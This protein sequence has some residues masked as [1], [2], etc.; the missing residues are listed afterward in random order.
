[1]KPKQ[2][3]LGQLLV[4]IDDSL[5]ICDAKSC[6]HSA[7]RAF[8]KQCGTSEQAII[9]HPLSQ[10]ISQSEL[11]NNIDPLKQVFK[12]NASWSGRLLVG[13]SGHRV[14]KSVEIS[15]IFTNKHQPKL[16]LLKIISDDQYTTTTK[17][18]NK[19]NIDELT[20]LPNQVLLK[21][22]IQQSMIN[23]KRAGKSVAVLL[24]SID[25][26][27]DI[28]AG[29]GQRFSDE[30]ICQVTG[31]L[32]NCIRKSDT[33]ARLMED[34]FAFVLQVTASDDSSIVSR[35]LLHSTEAA[36]AIDQQTVHIRASVGIS[37]YPSDS[38]TP[39]GLIELAFSAL[40][41]ARQEGG[42]CYD[43]FS[44]EMNRR[45]KARIEMEA[46]LRHGI[47]KNEFQ[48]FYQPK[49]RADDGRIVGMEGLIRWF[50][51]GTA[52]VSPGEFIP[53]AEETG[54]IEPIGMWVLEEACRQNKQWQ[55]Q[56]LG[57][58]K[59]SINVSG[60]QLNNPDFV[61]H[62]QDVINRVHINPEFLEL[63]I[64]ESMLAHNI[65]QTINKLQKI[66][67]LGCYLSIDDFGTGY[68]SLSYLTR[69]PITALKIDRA[70]IH[71][72]EVNENTAEV[73][74]AI[75]GLSQGLNLEVIAEGAENVHHIDFLR[76]HHCDAVQGFYYSRPLPANEFESLLKT[77]YIK[78]A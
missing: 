39:E 65:E 32:H 64:T 36:F 71:D 33:I 59:F 70:F 41:H 49:V 11:E 10:F 26:F 47:A 77:G 24:F 8:C 63:E 68:S 9:D 72:I 15:P 2:S 73:A 69:Y 16:W 45:A 75:I 21:D 67:E 50:E 53:V 35:K 76:A 40:N 61:Q 13:T 57:P 55:Q 3:V 52:M 31:R 5:I 4:S 54:L 23:A 42:N 60:R 58:V 74:K 17:G 66:R 27:S 38:E 51:N 37:L 44:T 19:T 25:R 22:R 48:L 30:L 18:N 34:T 1:M 29:F 28:K 43:Y 46:R 14:P 78:V 56:G 7:S 6:I 12:N 20:G 62:V